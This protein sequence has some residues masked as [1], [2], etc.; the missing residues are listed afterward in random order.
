MNETLQVILIKAGIAGAIFIISGIIA[1]VFPKQKAM[2]ITGAPAEKFGLFLS[3]LGNTRLGKKSMDRL[4]EGPIST[5]VA[6]VINMGQRFQKGLRADNLKEKME[7]EVNKD[8]NKSYQD[9][10]KEL[11]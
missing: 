8:I 11:K 1:R 4:E 2:D 3:A 6:I 5:I 10:V 9:A 7:K